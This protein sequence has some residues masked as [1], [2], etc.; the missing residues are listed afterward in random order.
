[1]QQ[2]LQ[3]TDDKQVFW[4]IKTL[5]KKLPCPV[6]LYKTPSFNYL[7]SLNLKLVEN[8]L[9]ALKKQKNT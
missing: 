9:F 3:Q 4:D 7:T 5:W 8:G 6:V 2:L 1:M